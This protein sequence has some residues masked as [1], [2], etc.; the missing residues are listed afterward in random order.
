MLFE[1]EK[2]EK[3]QQQTKFM[4]IC[5]LPFSIAAFNNFWF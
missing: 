3:Q 1:N 4:L 2:L 5:L